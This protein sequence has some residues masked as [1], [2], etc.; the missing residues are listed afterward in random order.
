MQRSPSIL[1]RTEDYYYDASRMK[2]AAWHFPNYCVQQLQFAIN[3]S[4]C[5]SCCMAR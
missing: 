1:A 3:L 5:F 2:P 4:P